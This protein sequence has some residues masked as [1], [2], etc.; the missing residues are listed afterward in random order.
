LA[1]LAKLIERLQGAGRRLVVERRPNDARVAESLAEARCVVF[2][3][4]HEGFGLPVVEALSAGVPVVTSNHGSL[5]EIGQGGGVVMVDPEEAD[6]VADAMRGL[7]LDDRLHAQLVAE[8]KARPIRTW[9]EYA[10][11]LW[12]VLGS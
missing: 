12:A 2:P 10:D 11:D 3:S 4:L 5:L 6:A 1:V 9:G 7:L 8:A